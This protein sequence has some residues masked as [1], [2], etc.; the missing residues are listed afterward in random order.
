MLDVNKFKKINDTYGHVEGDAAL[1]RCAEALKKSGGDSRNFIGRYGGDEFIIIAELNGDDDAKTLCDRI[2][3]KLQEI[4]IKDKIP[5]KLTFSF[6]YV[7]YDKKMKSI[8]DFID[9]AD[10][11]LY[12]AKIKQL[13]K[14]QRA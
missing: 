4:C 1:I 7:A 9:A 5:Y 6:G 3:D 12:E 11:K 14:K 10:Q 2:A 8:Q 13:N